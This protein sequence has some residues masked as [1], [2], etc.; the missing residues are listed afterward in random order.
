MES[1]DANVH[2]EVL[3]GHRSRLPQLSDRWLLRLVV[4]LAVIAAGSIATAV[5]YRS[6]AANARA[7]ARAA[8]ATM[9]PVRPP[10]RGAGQFS[11][12]LTVA[13]SRFPIGAGQHGLL[14]IVHAS[15]GDHRPVVM[16]AQFSGLSPGAFYR[17]TGGDCQEA[18][19]DF[20][21][22]E[23]KASR[24]G[25]LLLA[26]FPRALNPYHVYWM[27]FDR[28]G[29]RYPVG[30]VGALGSGHVSAFRAGHEPCAGE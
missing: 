9:S 5:H 23:G 3:E 8:A 2:E 25:D 26:T 7:A 1:G 22:A 13:N 15:A 29:G 27:S 10:F 17:L 18:A 30:V 6:G 28:P 12:S 20:V 24:S 16:V 14:A 19:P 4:V 21:W 11:T